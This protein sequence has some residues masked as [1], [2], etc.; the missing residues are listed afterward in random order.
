MPNAK[1]VERK[2]KSTHKAQSKTQE[3]FSVQHKKHTAKH[4]KRLAL[5]IER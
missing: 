1:R 2:I 3:A 4:R 5:S